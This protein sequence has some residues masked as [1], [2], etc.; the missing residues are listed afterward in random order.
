MKTGSS[1]VARP[2]PAGIVAARGVVTAVRARTGPAG[3]GADVVE[4]PVQSRG[5]DGPAAVLVTGLSHQAGGR[6]AHP[7][8]DSLNYALGLLDL[9]GVDE[10]ER[11]LA[12]LRGDDTSADSNLVSLRA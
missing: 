12:I 4:F 5:V 8:R 3:A 9:G 10:R 11:A 1:S 2:G 7:T 6:V